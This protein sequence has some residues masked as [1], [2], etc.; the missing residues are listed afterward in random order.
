MRQ[1]HLIPRELLDALRIGG[2]DVSPGDIGEN[3]TTSGLDLESLPL[4]TELRIGATTVIRLT[5]LR[6]PCVL[7]DRF[8]AGLK[9]RLLNGMPG[10]PFRAGVMAVVSVGGVI[11]PK[12]PIKAILSQAPH[13]RL[14][15]L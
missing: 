10:P 11:A 1:V 13:L 15:P 12:D 4:D 6:T 5:G 7:I 8:Q 14:P 2:Y 9:N 3:I